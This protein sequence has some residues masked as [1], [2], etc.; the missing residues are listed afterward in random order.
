MIIFEQTLGIDKLLTQVNKIQN[1][2]ESTEYDP[3]NGKYLF[4]DS[5]LDK[6]ML[7]L[8]EFQTR[9]TTINESIKSTYSI[10]K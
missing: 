4:K 7:T 9:H 5:D 1:Q 3:E 8:D 2:L 6:I 10:S